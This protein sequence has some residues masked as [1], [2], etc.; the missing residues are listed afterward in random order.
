MTKKKQDFHRSKA[1][2]KLQSEW[3]DRLSEDGFEDIEML[4]PR[5]GELSSQYLRGNISSTVT[6]ERNPELEDRAKFPGGLNRFHVTPKM[7]TYQ[8]AT[9]IA[10][11]F[12]KNGTLDWEATLACAMYADGYRISDIARDIGT[13]RRRVRKLLDPLKKA[14]DNEQ[15]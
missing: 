3:Y 5:T 8:L 12:L 10:L 14:L 15:E 11:G 7:E 1:F 4:D 6:T 9:D 13:T 2:R